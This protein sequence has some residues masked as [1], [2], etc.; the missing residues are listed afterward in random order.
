MKNQK[1][2]ILTLTFLLITPISFSFGA[3]KSTNAVTV[4]K[5]KIKTAIKAKA[6]LAKRCFAESLKQNKDLKGTLELSFTIDDKG[7]MTTIEI[8]REK[9]TI[10]DSTLEDCVMGIYRQAVLPASAY[11]TVT[12]VTYPF[13]FGES[14]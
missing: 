10:G 8:N 9:S 7:K 11:G 6:H 1:S 2:I 3:G 14:N 13:N 4:A 5:N 12:T